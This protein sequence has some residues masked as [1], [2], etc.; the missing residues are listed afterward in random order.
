MGIYIRRAPGVAV[1]VREPDIIQFGVDATRAGLIRVTN[2]PIIAD[3]LRRNADQATTAESLCQSLSTGG[4]PAPA[5]ASLVQ[6]LLAYGVWQEVISAS[7]VIVWGQSPLTA[8]L[9]D[10]LRADGFRVRSPSTT[11][12]RPADYVASHP[13]EVP[14]LLVD[15]AD[16]AHSLAV[17][18]AKDTRTWL[19]I[20]GFD[21]RVLVGPMRRAGHGPCPLC[22]NLY[23]AETDPLWPRTM[24]ELSGQWP[25]PDPLVAAAAAARVLPA[26]RSFTGRPPLPGS[27]PVR[28][29]PGELHEVDPFGS[30]H[31]RFLQTHPRCPACFVAGAPDGDSFFG[32]QINAPYLT[33][34][35]SSSHP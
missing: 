21:T 15:I 32:R 6:E 18:L 16:D 33:P 14:L 19:P 35:R 23:R 8:M 17:T 27:S 20:T 34:K 12:T 26:L 9:A 30:T 2:A 11:L 10:A 1:I 25:E 24:M 5:A 13:E 4:I 28:W 29:V 22:L 7:P 3:I 31:V